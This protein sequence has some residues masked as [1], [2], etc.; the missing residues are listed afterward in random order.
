MHK[1]DELLCGYHSKQPNFP[2]YIYPRKVQYIYT[3]LLHSKVI[4]PTRKE[5]I[6]AAGSKPLKYNKKTES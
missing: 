3:Q 6:Q 2:D 4:F 1:S 5:N